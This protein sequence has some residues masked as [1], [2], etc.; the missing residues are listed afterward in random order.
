MGQKTHPTG[1]R[2]GVNK[3]HSST[4]F[5]NYGAYKQVLEEDYRIRK[6]IEKLVFQN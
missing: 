6:F 1:F 3:A 5:A 2:I 4:W